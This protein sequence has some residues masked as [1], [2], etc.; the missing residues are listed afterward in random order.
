MNPLASARRMLTVSLVL[1]ALLLVMVVAGIWLMWGS[2][3]VWAV[4]AFLPLLAIVGYQIWA[5]DS[6]LRS[7]TQPDGGHLCM[8]GVCGR[9]MPEVAPVD[10]RVNVAPVQTVPERRR[11]RFLV[12]AAAVIGGLGL[13]AT[14]VALNA[15][16]AGAPVVLVPSVA[17]ALFVIAGVVTL[18][19]AFGMRDVP[20]HA[21][22]CRWC[23]AAG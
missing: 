8:C 3:F 7:H 16:F 12:A 5:Q 9:D 15:E 1:L 10:L 22:A 13:A 11:S 18:V 14:A 4:A 6:M 17:A 23:G 2:P 21:C 20:P 19:T